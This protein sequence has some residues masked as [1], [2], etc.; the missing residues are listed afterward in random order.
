MDLGT[1]S[2]EAG[3]D[4]SAKQYIAIVETSD[5][6]EVAGA[7]TGIG[8]LQNDPVAG[9][10]A[11]VRI[12]GESF[13]QA[14]GATDIAKWDPLASN[15]SGILVKDTTDNNKVMALA[16]EAYTKDETATIRVFV[17]PPARY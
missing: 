4:L 8:I 3:S 10:P 2:I 12:L 15:A 17:I 5:K 9:Q 16:L 6:A 14:N 11:T 13:A 1:I 7:N